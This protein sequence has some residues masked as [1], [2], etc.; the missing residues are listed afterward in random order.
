MGAERVTWSCLWSPRQIWAAGLP[1]DAAGSLYQDCT[2][3]VRSKKAKAKQPPEG[4]GDKEED[5]VTA[6]TTVY[7][8]T[9]N[10]V[11]NKW[12]VSD[13]QGP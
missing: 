3:Q 10:K 8:Q 4:W 13:F 5:D 1:Q 7:K 12:E 9:L 6:K 11:H 2:P